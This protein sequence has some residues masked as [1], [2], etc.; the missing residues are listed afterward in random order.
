MADTTI[1]L[2]PM[3]FKLLGL[4]A[5]HEKVTP[6]E[7]ICGLLRDEVAK[8]MVNEASKKEGHQKRNISRRLALKP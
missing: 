5:S 4:L 8:T 3:E 2:P 6:E 7:Y 1:T